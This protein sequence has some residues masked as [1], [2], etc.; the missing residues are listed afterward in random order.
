MELNLQIIKEELVD[1]NLKAHLTDHYL[2]RR[3]AYPTLYN[4]QISPEGTILYLAEGNRLPEQMDFEAIPS[5]ICIGKPP[6]HYL[7]SRCNILYAD[8]DINLFDLLNRIARIF[9]NYYQWEKN[10][11]EINNQ[12]LPLRV[13]GEESE[14][15]FKKPFGLFESNFRVIFSIVNKKRY[16]VND[17]YNL[18]S[19]DLSYCDMD[20]INSLKIDPEFTINAHAVEPIIYSG[21]VHGFRSLVSNIRLNDVNVASLVIYEIGSE[22]TDRD[23]A[24][25]QY[26]G[27]ILQI[28]L[29]RKDI[30]SFNQPNDFIDIMKKILE[31]RMVDEERILSVLVQNEWQVDDNY[32]CIHVEPSLDDERNNSLSTLAIQISVHSFDNAFII[33]DNHLIFLFNLTK[34]KASREQVLSFVQPQ[35]RDCLLKAGISTVFS[36]F[37]NL[38]YYNHQAAIALEIGKVKSPTRWYYRFEEYSLDYIVTKSKEKLIPE[39]LCPVGLLEL[40]KYDI[41]KG[42]NYYHLLRTYL[43]NNL[44][45]AKTIRETY[46]HRNTFLYQFEKIEK[47]LNLDITKPDVYLNLLLAFR[48]LESRFNEKKGDSN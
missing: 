31:H 18:E 4:N 11:T 24:L 23:F 15:I 17:D 13:L 2:L 30:N 25:A 12:N 10:M 7:S 41:N 45:I 5:F 19:I 34:S 9:H 8:A 6:E 35:L 40:K 22:F 46:L 1:L 42:T 39:V 29:S 16:V 33:F 37:K 20:E 14:P 26:F 43:E 3:L 38:Y 48:I 47:I 32:F 28:R 27:E 21:E 36:D 44:N